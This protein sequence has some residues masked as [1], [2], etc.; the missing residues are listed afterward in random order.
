MGA[1]VARSFLA[2]EP[3][4]VIGGSAVGVAM[5]VKRQGT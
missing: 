2:T 3:G 5:A 1:S 4:S